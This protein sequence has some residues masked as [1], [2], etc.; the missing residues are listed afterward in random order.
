MFERGDR[1]RRVGIILAEIMPAE[2]AAKF[3]ECLIEALVEGAIV[4]LYVLRLFVGVAD[5]DGEAGQDD[6]LV[7][8]AALA[9]GAPLRSA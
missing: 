5:I 9:D 7:G 1:E 3:G 4:A 6:D 2:R 8:I